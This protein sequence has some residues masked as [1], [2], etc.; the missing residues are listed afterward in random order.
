MCVANRVGDLPGAV[1]AAGIVVRTGSVITAVYGRK[2]IRGVSVHTLNKDASGYVSGVERIACGAVA[3]SG[4]WNPTVHLFSQS[5]GKLRFDDALQAFVPDQTVSINP[6]VSVGACNG[7]YA[8]A[9]CLHE[10]HHT[11]QKVIASLGKSCADVRPANAAET[12]VGAGQ[13]LWSLPDDASVVSPRCKQ[14]HDLQNDVTLADIQLAYREGYESVEHLKR[15]TTTGMG[16]DQGK[17][18]NVI[19][20]ANLAQL[21]NSTIPGR[22]YHYLQATVYAGHVRRYCRSALGRIVPAETHNTDAA[23]A[24]CERCRIRGCW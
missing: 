3:V 4:G 11:M 13:S 9:D 6:S 8:L 16:T 23:M 1:T 12:Q 17:T 20:L 22:R 19:A 21:K 24:P 5:R 18:S 10:A 2:R 7:T 14:F 15:Y